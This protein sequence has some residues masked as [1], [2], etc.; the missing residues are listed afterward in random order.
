[1]AKDVDR[2]FVANNFRFQQGGE[3]M[4]EGDIVANT[5]ILKVL[6]RTSSKRS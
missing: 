6:T 1:M 5:A 4:S 3:R 2:Y